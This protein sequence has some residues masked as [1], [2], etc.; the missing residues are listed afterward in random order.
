MRIKCTL[1]SPR[2]LFRDLQ[3]AD[4]SL[5]NEHTKSST[6]IESAGDRG[7]SV[8]SVMV[9][10]EPP[11]AANAGVNAMLRNVGTAQSGRLQSLLQ[12]MRTPG[13]QVHVPTQ[14]RIFF[15]ASYRVIVQIDSNLRRQG[16]KIHVI[17]TG[18]DKRK[19]LSSCKLQVAYCSAIR[20]YPLSAPQLR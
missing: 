13:R 1:Q 15:H 5:R 3:M 19:A 10:L 9:L 4:G 20:L 12:R 11:I 7:C 6:L 16:Q 18:S 14:Q 8:L 17:C 2:I